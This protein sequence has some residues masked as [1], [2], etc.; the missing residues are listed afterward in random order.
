MTLA[1]FLFLIGELR[2]SGSK[3]IIGD[4]T[5]DLIVVQV[6]HV[7]LIGKAGIGGHNG[8]GLIDVVADL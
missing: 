8:A 2:V 6:L 3:L 5:V 4:I 7:G 1:I